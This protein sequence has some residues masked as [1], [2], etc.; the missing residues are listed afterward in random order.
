[1]S[2]SSSALSGLGKT[3]SPRGDEE[4]ISVQIQNEN[5]TF[6]NPQKCSYE[7]NSAGI[8]FEVKEGEGENATPT[9]LT[10]KEVSGISIVQYQDGTD[11]KS[12]RFRL[13]I[14]R[15]KYRRPPLW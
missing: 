7:I 15:W 8:S 5:G 1:M 3:A 9:G 14:G 4:F 6:S 2:G 10:T 13:G 11:H 12:L